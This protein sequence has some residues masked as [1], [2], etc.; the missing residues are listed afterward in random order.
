VGYLALLLLFFASPALLLAQFQLPTDEELKMTA[1]PKAPGAAAVF[2]NVEEITDDPHNS[3][4]FYARIKV[5]TE[6]GK[7]LATVELPPYL[8]GTS[9]IT[10]IKGR[11]IHSDGAV[12]PLI[13]K[14]QDLLVVKGITGEGE[15]MQVNR[16]VFTLPSVEVGSI[17]EYTYT[18]QNDENIC[19][20]PH[21]EIQRPYFVHKA[22]YFFTPS[23]QF[24]RGSLN[25]SNLYME[26]EHQRLINS[27]IWW[28]HLPAG[29]S[30]KSD[31]SGHISVDIADVPPA[32]DEE[33]MPPV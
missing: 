21:W 30:V 19:S 1:D 20:S 11:T 13:G 31:T 23:R 25:Q 28:K 32:P 4:S 27:I 33:W 3:Q 7:E 12:I 6:K 15:Q 14:P 26:D 17:L 16:K 18:I 29:V 22:H 2:L 8:R 24:L 9:K 5:L 10:D